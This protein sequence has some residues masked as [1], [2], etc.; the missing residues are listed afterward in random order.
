MSAT[1]AASAQLLQLE[2]E[3]LQQREQT[4]ADQQAAA[5][6][7]TWQPGKQQRTTSG[8]HRPTDTVYRVSE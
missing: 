2:R 6:A 3:K 1:P 8:A 7:P 5:T 4:N